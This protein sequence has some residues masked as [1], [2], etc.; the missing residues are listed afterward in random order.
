MTDIDYVSVPTGYID[1]EHKVNV[2]VCYACA[3]GVPAFYEKLPVGTRCGR[4]RAVLMRGKTSVYD[5][6][7]FKTGDGYWR[8][9]D[10]LDVLDEIVHGGDFGSE[11]KRKIGKEAE[12]AQ[13]RHARARDR[14]R[15]TR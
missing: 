1:H 10:G 2:L 7:G 9:A 4:C 15:H 8:P 5:E 12:K 11:A 6:N 14:V 13:L 3:D